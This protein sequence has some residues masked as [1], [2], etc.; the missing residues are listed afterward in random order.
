V[1]TQ[2]VAPRITSTGNTV[3]VMTYE[4][5]FTYPDG[6]R[7]SYLLQQSPNRW[8]EVVATAQRLW[9]KRQEGKRA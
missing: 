7:R 2:R 3:Y 4:Y 8:R 9:A 5:I 6:Y 1:E